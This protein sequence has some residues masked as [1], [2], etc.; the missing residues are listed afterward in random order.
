MIDLLSQLPDSINIELLFGKKDFFRTTKLTGISLTAI[1]HFQDDMT[2]GYFLTTAK[3]ET[4]I[5]LSKRA[6]ECPRL[7]I[8]IELV[9]PE[10]NQFGG[11]EKRKKGKLIPDT[12]NEISD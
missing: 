8:R 2:H 9:G 11:K 3:Q 5:I 1:N 7:I 4:K 6:Q 12:Q 10:R